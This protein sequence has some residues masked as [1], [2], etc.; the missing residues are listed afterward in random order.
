MGATA[1]ERRA[2]LGLCAANDPADE[3]LADAVARFGV[4]DVWRSLCASGEATALARRAAALDLDAVER[5][6]RE[7]GLRFVVPGDDEWPAAIDDLSWGEA[8]GTMRGAAFGLWVAGRRSLG[9]AT[10][11]SVAI[12]GSRAATA[13]GE[14]VTSDLAYGVA[15]QG[16]AVISG[17][18]Y[19]IDAAA[20]RGALVANGVTVAVLAGGLAAYYPLGNTSLFEQIRETGLLVSEAPPDRP[21]S[22]T[23]FLSRNRLIAA[24]TQG[25]VI[26][27]GGVRSGAVNTVS[28]AMSLNRLVLAV[29]GPVTSALSYS[30][31]RLIRAGQAVLAATA[32]DI[33]EAIRPLDPTTAGERKDPPTLFDE[34]AGDEQTVVEAMPT[35]GWCAPDD[36]GDVTGEPPPRLL[37]LL[38]RL[39]ERGIVVTDG[40]GRWKRAPRRNGG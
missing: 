36:L 27:E 10:A 35:R 14:H 34:L 9:E 12:V 11:G 33:I 30:P 25:T 19:G 16:H 3:A 32:D 6:T 21:P 37:T 13:Y 8:V 4:V 23:R 2:R 20:H 17:G 5:R 39:E 24:L 15:E 18:A 28:W 29:P 22:R 1:E 31:H 26:V 40:R 7:C 38:T